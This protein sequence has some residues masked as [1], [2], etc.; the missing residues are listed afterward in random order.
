ML[1]EEKKGHLPFCKNLT[2]RQLNPMYHIKNKK[3][4]ELSQQEKDELFAKV[5]N[6]RVGEENRSEENRSVSSEEKVV[7]KVGN[8]EEKSQ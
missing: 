5:R 3:K 6:Q 2:L 7:E 4:H 1:F 8:L